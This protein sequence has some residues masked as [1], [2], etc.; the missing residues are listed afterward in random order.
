MAID[1]TASQGFIPEIF[2]GTAL[3]RLRNYL[4]LSR[5][6]TMN[7]DLETG[8]TFEVG[9]ILHLPKRGTLSVNQKTE[10]GNVT[11]QSPTSSTVDV[12]LNHHLEV[13]FALT[14]EAIAFQN[15]DQ[16]QGYVNDAI[17]A[18]AEE[19]DNSLFQAWKLVPSSQ[20]VTNGSTITE[21][22]ILTARQYLRTNKVQPNAKMYGV[23]GLSQEAAI[24]QLSNL[25]RFDAIGVTNNVPNAEIGDGQISMPGAIGRAYGFEICPSQLVPSV[26][27]NDNTLQTVTL[28]AGNTG[29]SFTLTANGITTKP[30]PYNATA[31]AVQIA[32]YQAYGLNYSN[33]GPFPQGQVFVTGAAGG[34]YTV[35]QIIP[36]GATSYAITGAGALTGGTNTVTIAQVSQTTGSKNLFYTQDA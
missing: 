2:L 33:G 17:I 10:T 4:T 31:L 35:A 12:V 20:T 32:L 25:V 1:S 14:S 36:L 23:V 13:T 19:I 16:A 21:P 28:G 27:A 8:E 18:L 15:Q 24:F 5:T 30:I 29:G 6:V 26:S 34:P 22:N 3:G 7:T 9:K 11:V